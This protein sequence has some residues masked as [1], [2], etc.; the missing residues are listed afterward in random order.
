MKIHLAI[1]LSIFCLALIS[2][3]SDDGE[4][5][6]ETTESA[7]STDQPAD[8]STSGTVSSQS[9]LKTKILVN[10]GAYVP[11]QCYTKTEDAQG[12]V[13][14]PCYTCHLASD[15]PNYTND[16]DLQLNYA[17]PDYL[18]TNHWS[19]L[20]K[21][22]RDEVAA[23]SDEEILAYVRTSNYFNPNKEIILANR[24]HNLPPEWDFNDNGKWDG[25]I[26]DCYFNFDEEGFDRDW[27]GKDT[28]WRAFAYYPFPGTFWPTNGSTDDVIIRLPKSF[29]MTIDGQLSREVYKLNLAIV[30]ALIKREDVAIPPVDESIYGIDLDRN[31]AFNQAEKVVYDWAPLEGREMQYVGMAQLEV[32][33]GTQQIAAGLFPLETEFLHTVRYIDFDEQDNVKLAARMKEVRYARKFYWQNY[34]ELENFAASEIKEKHDFPDRLKQVIGNMEQGV[35][36]GQGWVYQG[37]IEEANGDLRPQTYEENV[38]CVGCHA[39]VGVITDSVFAFPRKLPNP[40]QQ[41]RGWYHWSQKDL[42]GLEEPRRDD[43]QYEYTFYLQQNK[44]GDEFRENQEVMNRFFNSDGSLREDKIA[45]LHEDIS[46]LLYPSR[47]RG[48]NL[49]KAYRVIV[50]EQSF[51]KGR[52][53]TIIPSDNIHRKVESDQPTGIEEMVDG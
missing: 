13:H 25:Y 6:I 31:G 46:L 8:N 43:G 17:F 21:D 11:P 7:E 40:P 38:F 51:I 5:K 39:T 53:A 26:P 44:A 29:R 22:R 14:N 23:I 30:E 45:V 15:P 28:G 27:Q 35:S 34:G 2:C 10:P 37:F 42:V 3:N 36:T 9:S 50:K 52:D 19:N 24:L 49:N 48:L 12:E 18:L 32:E 20:F 1:A 41:E 47:Q 33:A 16:P 4:E